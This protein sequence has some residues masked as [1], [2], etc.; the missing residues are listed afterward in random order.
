M[1]NDKPQTKQ[2]A[3]QTILNEVFHLVASRIDVYTLL[4]EALFDTDDVE[5]TDLYKVLEYSPSKC[6]GIE[7]NQTIFLCII[8]LRHHSNR[9]IVPEI[10]F[11]PGKSEPYSEEYTVMFTYNDRIF[12]FDYSYSSYIGYYFYNDNTKNVLSER[13]PQKRI[14]I[15]YIIKE[16]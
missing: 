15:D 13:I 6:Y 4:E 14:V 3:L 12:S 9:G 5:V 16:D 10:E 2:D 1:S 11:L 7:Y 8:A